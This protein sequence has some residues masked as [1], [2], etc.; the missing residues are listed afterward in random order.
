MSQY[1]GVTNRFQLGETQVGLMETQFQTD[2]SSSEIGINIYF[3]TEIPWKALAL[4]TD[5][6]MDKQ[7]IVSDVLLQKPGH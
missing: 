2:K 5:V 1:E 6:C 7:V 3:S 4:W